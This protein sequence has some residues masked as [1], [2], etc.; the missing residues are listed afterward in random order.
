MLFHFGFVFF[1]FFYLLFFYYFVV[2][3]LGMQRVCG[4]LSS[5]PTA[6]NLVRGCDRYCLVPQ[7]QLPENSYLIGHPCVVMEISLN[8][9]DRTPYKVAIKEGFRKTDLVLNTFWAS[10]DLLPAELAKS[11]IPDPLEDYGPP[12]VTG[13]AHSPGDPEPVLTEIEQ[14]RNQASFLYST[15]CKASDMAEAITA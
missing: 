13:R 1:C 4:S 10:A 2:A 7:L 8:D 5:L 6:Q 15:H 11:H 12:V 3:V 14:S 9:L